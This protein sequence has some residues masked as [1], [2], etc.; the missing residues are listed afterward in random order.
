MINLAPSTQPG[1]P[2]STKHQE[3][4]C[5]SGWP[6]PLRATSSGCA[7]PAIGRQWQG[8]TL[9]RFETSPPAPHVVA[10]HDLLAS[11]QVAQ[12]TP[13]HVHATAARWLPGCHP[14]SAPL[15]PVQKLGQ[16]AAS[17]PK[18][19]G[20]CAVPTES[21]LLLVNGGNDPSTRIMPMMVFACWLASLPAARPHPG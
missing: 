1:T 16:P 19:C 11:F 20:Q 15:A 3:D 9:G 12:R 7:G 8:T 17:L 18:R 14:V 13:H 5:I 2:S 6:S 10:L 21:R 4:T